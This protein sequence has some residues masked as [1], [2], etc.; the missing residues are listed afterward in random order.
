ML[1]DIMFGR[2]STPIPVVKELDFPGC[3]SREFPELFPIAWEAVET[4]RS[5]L[6]Q[7]DDL[8]PLERHSP[9]LRGFDW[10][11][12]LR[13]SVIRMLHAQQTLVSAGV[14]SGRILDLGSYLGNFALMFARFGYQ[15]DALDSYRAYGAATEPTVNA[16]R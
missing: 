14:R 4:A 3:V 6:T 2:R 9:G 5:A 11:S 7:A 8:T 13:L 1:R 12:Y 15:T 16:M 10:A